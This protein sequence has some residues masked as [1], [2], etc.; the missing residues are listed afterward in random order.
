[1]PQLTEAANLPLPPFNGTFGVFNDTTIRQTV[2]LSV[3]GDILRIRLSNAF[4]ATDLP[5]TAMTIAHPIPAVNQSIGIPEI[6][7]SSVQYVTFS[8]SRNFTIPDQSLIV[9]DPIHFP[10]KDLSTISLSIYLAD[11]QALF[12]ISSHPGSR[13][14]SW[15]TFGNHVAD[16]NITVTNVTTQE[17]F[18]WYYISAVEVWAPPPTSAFAV[19]GD[20]ITDGRSSDN[21]GNNRWTDIVAE[22][23]LANPSTKDISMLNQAAG[24]N[25]ILYDGNGPNALSRIERDVIAQSGVKY[26]MIFEG[27]N[28]IGTAATTVEAQNAVADRVIAAYKQIVTRVHTF[29][30]PMFA[31]TITPFGCPNTTI[32]PYSDPTREM[33]RQK[34]NK[35]IRESG[36]FDAV[37]DFDAWIRNPANHTENNPKLNSGDCLHPNVA[38]YKLL[39]DNFPLEIFDKFKDGVNTFS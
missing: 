33:A 24:G 30:I 1:M 17:I 20:S 12:N 18:H 39:G 37:I 25:R 32:Q 9:S 4:G 26:A 38:G 36:I 23:M 11:G 19:V 10:V 3:G 28:D 7:P 35:F 22:R 16:R 31:A 29:G 34:V 2:R 15:L 21:N 8:G 13:V 6:E 5:I 14:S 27:V